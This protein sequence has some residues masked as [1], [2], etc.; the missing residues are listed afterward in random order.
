MI[1]TVEISMYPIRD[2]YLPPID[3]VIEKLNSFDDLRVATFTTAT[4]IIGEYGAV[5]AAL[6]ETIAW[7][8]EAFGTSVFVT[9]IIPG[10]DP[11][12]GG[13]T[14]PGMEEVERR[15]KPKPRAKQEARADDP[16]S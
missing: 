14:T 5:M 1:T 13:G 4:T 6:Q 12:D 7:S 10:Y 3:A 11:M 9:K 2:D 15:R 8:F 16:D